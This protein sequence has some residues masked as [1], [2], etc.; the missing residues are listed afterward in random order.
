MKRLFRC[1][2]RV[3]AVALCASFVLGLSGCGDSNDDRETK[4]EDRVSLPE[5]NEIL[6]VER[7]INFAWGYQDSGMF[8]T[9]EGEVYYYDFSDYEVSLYDYEN[10]EESLIETLEKYRDTEKP[11]KTI[12]RALVKEMYKA[13]LNIDVNETYETV[14]AACDAGSKVLYIHDLNTGEL[15]ACSE[16]GDYE[17]ELQSREGQEFITFYNE[18]KKEISRR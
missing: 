7:Y 17:G 2:K 1:I 3:V 8:I 5:N 16:T 6:V 15:I 14:W 9:S 11:D 18:I 13:M 10:K 4:K 12:G